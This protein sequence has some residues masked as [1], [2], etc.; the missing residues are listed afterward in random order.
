MAT[1]AKLGIVIYGDGK[2]FKKE[3]KSVADVAKS[4]GSQMKGIKVD[5]VSSLTRQVAQLGVAYAGIK[6]LQWGVDMAFQAERA[7]VVM[8]KM[9]GSAANA[10]QFMQE[11]KDVV[12][13]GQGGA[14]GVMDLTRAAQQLLVYNFTLSDTK[15][16]LK[17][18]GDAAAAFP[19][20]PAIVIERVTR[21]L[22]QMKS[23]G[24]VRADEIKQ[25]AELGIPV[26][27]NLAKLMNK[28][29]PDVM[30]AVTDR[31]VGA[32]IGIKAVM[33]SMQERFAGTMRVMGNTWYGLW[34][35]IKNTGGL[36]I[37][38]IMEQIGQKIGGKDWMRG[39]GDWLDS[40]VQRAPQI[41][42]AI[43][44]VLRPIA[45][46]LSAITGAIAGL[47]QVIVR[48]FAGAHV[49]SFIKKLGG[50]E[51]IF[52]RI[53]N[54]VVD[55]LLA[56]M[57]HV[58]KVFDK[59]AVWIEPFMNMELKQKAVAAHKR[60]VA[61][62]AHHNAVRGRL[63]VPGKDRW[64]AKMAWLDA[65]KEY[66]SLTSDIYSD[67]VPLAKKID[68]MRRQIRRDRRNEWWSGLGQGVFDRTLG[69]QGL[70]LQALF[71]RGTIFD[72]AIDVNSLD[73]VQPKSAG[74]LGGIFGIMGNLAVNAPALTDQMKEMAEAGA[75]LVESWDKIEEAA[76]KFRQELESPLEKFDREIK[77]IAN[78]D[79]LT[80]AEKDDIFVDR[81]LRETSRFDKG[82][83][84]AQDRSENTALLAGS[85][86]AQKTMLD[87][88]MSGFGKGKMTVEEK[89]EAIRKENAD[90]KK[91]AAETRD[92]LK[93]LLTPQVA[94]F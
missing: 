51:G 71:G 47:G 36:A 23:K 91:I 22:G 62:E 64:N 42:D 86:E 59:L 45:A 65:T 12:S 14:F 85:K 81:F 34:E 39:A 41:A 66:F 83:K 6:G 87:A 28:P 70:G 32:D 20:D 30:Q 15:K 84:G 50:I 18:V 78:N 55:G 68:L 16:M 40:I 8:E 26:W 82:I 2:Q 88:Q 43:L 48:S 37:Q 33:I 49:D 58:A 52:I 3:A 38:A 13:S 67:R 1:I 72:R 76:S 56:A 46:V 57:Y 89:L 19:A 27:E 4:L 17:L 9:T 25:L 73:A 54:V 5:V 94:D 80:G 29:L 11:I 60:M 93:R 61:A 75:K 79:E 7:Q 44:S 35:R 63:D 77:E 10:A 69:D 24:Q 90:M 21:A 31:K 74:A 53:K 92:E